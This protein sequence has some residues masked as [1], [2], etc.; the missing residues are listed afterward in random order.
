M[1]YKSYARGGRGPGDL[2]DLYW[3][4]IS[5]CVVV[6][7]GVGCVWCCVDR[8]ALVYC[9]ASVSFCFSIYINYLTLLKNIFN[10]FI[11]Y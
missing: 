3:T 4:S 6:W 2:G 11:L 7:L 9:V 10:L 8:R 5:G 1:K